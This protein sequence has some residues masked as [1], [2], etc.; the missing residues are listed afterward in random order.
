MIITAHQG[1]IHDGMR[2]KWLFKYTRDKV[3]KNAVCVNMFSR[4]QSSKFR[5]TY[6]NSNI[7]VIPLALKNYGQPSVSSASSKDHIVV[8]LSFGVITYNKYI[9]LLIEAACNLY[10]K[11]VRG[12]K[13]KLYGS[14][15]FWNSYKSK[16]RYNEI[17]ENSIRHID[18]SEIPNL[19]AGAHY[20][21]Q[22]YRI[23]TQSGVTKIAYN[24]YTP[25]IVS[26]LDGFMDEFDESISGFSFESENVE[27]LE[28]VMRY[29]IEHHEDYDTLVDKM[30]SFVDSVYSDEAIGKMYLKMFNEITEKEK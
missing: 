16:I 20:V 3:Y 18:N 10:E 21:V 9:E 14:C 26:R 25:I 28:R 6:P 27:D 12:F 19:F 8:F 5:K 15:H 13:V 17:F 2:P 29:V 30:H 1:E 24:Y 11:G 7:H 22:P 4:F 23:V